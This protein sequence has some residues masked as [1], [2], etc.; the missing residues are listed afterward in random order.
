[1][2]WNTKVHT[3][4]DFANVPAAVASK[5]NEIA[6]DAG[7]NGNGNSTIAGNSYQHWR[8]GSERIFG[9]W[10]VGAQMFNFVAYGTHSGTGNRSYRVTLGDGGTR[11]ISTE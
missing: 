1:M 3:A 6:T 4:F 9:S 10:A 8:S 11:T 7:R 2:P 5:V